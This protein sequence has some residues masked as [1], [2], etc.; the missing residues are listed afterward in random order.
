MAF[1]KTQET[2]SGFSLLKKSR[3]RAFFK[4]GLRRRSPA[5]GTSASL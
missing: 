4:N 5:E 2:G 3:N 1:L